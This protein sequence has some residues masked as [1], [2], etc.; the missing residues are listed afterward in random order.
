MQKIVDSEKFYGLQVAFEKLDKILSTQWKNGLIPHRTGFVEREWDVPHTALEGFAYDTSGIT[1]PPLLGMVLGELFDKKPFHMKWGDFL[2]GLE[3]YHTYLYRFRD[4]E[5]TGLVSI[6]HPEESGARSSSAYETVDT[7]KIINHF[8]RFGYD[9]NIIYQESSFNVKDV[10]F[11]TLLVM[12]LR[13]EYE[14]NKKLYNLTNDEELLQRASLAKRR[15]LKTTSSIFETL[16]DEEET[17]FFNYDVREEKRKE[18]RTFH[19]LIPL[20]LGV[21][22]EKTEKT[23]SMMKSSHFQP[24][25][26]FGVTTTSMESGV[27]RPDKKWEGSVSPVVN[28]L[29]WKGLKQ[30]HPEDARDMLSQSTSLI[31]ESFRD[32]EGITPAKSLLQYKKDTHRSLRDELMNILGWLEIR[33][34]PREDLWIRMEDEELPNRDLA[35][36]YRTPLFAEAYVPRETDTY[37]RGAPLDTHSVSSA[38]VFLMMIND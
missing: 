20:V 5:D 1:H 32:E 29:L 25:Q 38:S 19:S 34:K 24:Q 21:K 15:E 31:S 10:F 22:N 14:M 35:N 6:V 28:W 26:G 18:I 23:L 30:Y 12:S 36:K 2:E 9:Q 33:D 37:I 7:D 3:R 8:S 11:N 4:P 16:W 13:K 27:F 17:C